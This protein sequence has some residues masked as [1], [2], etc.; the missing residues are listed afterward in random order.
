MES[1]INDLNYKLCWEQIH[2]KNS[3]T[4]LEN[5]VAK[6][7]EQN[8]DDELNKIMPYMSEYYPVLT[9]T[10]T[11]G[12][13][14]SPQF[15][16]DYPIVVSDEAYKSGLSDDY[17]TVLKIWKEDSTVI[18]VVPKNAPHKIR[19]DVQK[20]KA[21]LY[22]C[23]DKYEEF[24]QQL[25]WFGTV[26]PASSADAAI[27]WCDIDVDE[28]ATLHE[29]DFSYDVESGKITLDYD[30][31]QD[32]KQKLYDR[33]DEVPSDYKVF[34]VF[35]IR[36]DKYMSMDDLDDLEELSS[37]QVKQMITMQSLQANI[38]E[39]YYQF[40][41][42]TQTQQLLNELAYTVAVTVLST[43]V[44]SPQKILGET[45]EEMV[46]DPL[47]G[48]IS[49]GITRQF[50]DD[51]YTEM[52][53]IT[54]VESLRE[55]KGVMIAY[56]QQSLRTRYTSEINQRMKAESRQEAAQNQASTKQE[57]AQSTDEQVPDTAI[58]TLR[59]FAGAIEEDN[60]RKAIID[61]QLMSMDLKQLKKMS[62]KTGKELLHE[63][64]GKQYDE[65]GGAIENIFAKGIM[66]KTY[67]Y[68]NKIGAAIENIFAKGIMGKIAN[69][70]KPLP[71]MKILDKIMDT[72]GM[73]W[74]ELWKEA[75]H[76]PALEKLM[77]EASHIPD[78]PMAQ[79]EQ[80]RMDEYPKEVWFEH[81]GERVIDLIIDDNLNLKKKIGKETKKAIEDL[82]RQ[83]EQEKKFKLYKPDEIIKGKGYLSLLEADDLSDFEK[84]LDL[85]KSGQRQ[86]G[87]YIYLVE[88]F[89]RYYIGL[90]ER[91]LEIRFEE[92]I[93]DALRG[94]VITG[95]DINKPGFHRFYDAIC[96]V[97]E[98]CYGDLTRLYREL[99]TYSLL[100]RTDKRQAKL[101]EIYD[102]IDPFIKKHIIEIHEGSKML[103]M[104][105][106]ELIEKFPYK[107]LFEEGIIE[108]GIYEPE[109]DYMALRTDPRGLNTAAGGAGVSVSLPLYDIAIMV[110]LGFSA[111]KIS[112]ILQKKYKIFIGYTQKQFQTTIQHKIEDI[113]GGAYKAQEE[114][115]KPI[116]EHLDNI[117][118]LSRHD[119]YLAFKDVEFMNAWFY[120]W[121]YGREFLRK[122]IEKVCEIFNLDSESSWEVIQS[123]LDK[124]ERYYA[125]VPESQWREWFLLGHPYQKRGGSHAIPYLVG[126]GDKKSWLISMI[127][128]HKN[129][130]ENVE[131][132]RHNL[133]KEYVKDA[134]RKGFIEIDGEQISLNSYN[135]F[136]LIYD[137]VFTKY[138]N[139]GA[140]AYFE[141]ELFSGMTV[142][143]IY[144]TF[145][146]G[147]T[148]NP[149]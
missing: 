46:L 70:K 121:S 115:L 96:S 112:E 144:Y 130:F 141:K 68:Y 116:I 7:T 127:I 14:P 89:G 19:A 76:D 100:R 106:S 80:N 117:E 77:K 131:M 66:G 103:G 123:H 111:R 99:E 137:N 32:L 139:Y 71:P 97:L 63:L 55:S 27:D 129:G 43:A 79:G 78:T 31:C 1:N 17:Q 50:T 62:K 135:Y 87:G 98:L 35:E 142:E 24:G 64:V 92:H 148:N 81:D 40:Q 16:E 65:I 61:F 82:M 67:Q 88:V 114:F 47:L 73:T 39:Y 124:S 12:P 45:L 23:D 54:V 52:L 26:L 126:L 102:A 145:Y 122:D 2:A 4:Y 109:V 149:Y 119:I 86:Y 133:R 5:E 108:L 10:S 44:S 128:A 51:P 36:F 118:G 13:L 38:M 6:R 59:I 105:E 125:G 94:Y 42:A 138:K 95:G 18:R 49:G 20:I 143:Q 28:I 85:Y 83:L 56:R 104:R 107:K 120:E 91:T 113:F 72:T 53:V 84:A 48:S 21:Y 58:T 34:I 110:A 11:D 15:Y 101:E 41:V 134:L 30:V 147:G 9:F 146:L 29:G 132:F 8:N 74:M 60:T 69:N 140:L 93:I 75:E 57:L 22:S 33:Y 25:G 136:E 37:E 90:T 3:I